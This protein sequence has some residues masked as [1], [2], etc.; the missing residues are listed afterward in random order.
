MSNAAPI[1]IGDMRNTGTF[2]KNTPVPNTSGGTDDNYSDLLTCRGRLR[3]QSGNKA[4]EQGDIVQNKRY[5][6]ICRFQTALVID[7]DLILVIKGQIYRILDFEK[8]DELNHFYRFII[9]VF[10]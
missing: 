1:S 10:Q 4:Y 8:I 5:E 7:T 9:S 3:Q 2:R 6:W